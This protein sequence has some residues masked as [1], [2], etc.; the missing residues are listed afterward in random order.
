[1][2]KCFMFCKEYTRY[3][4]KLAL[5]SFSPLFLCYIPDIVLYLWTYQS[6]SRFNSVLHI[7]TPNVLL[8][9]PAAPP[10]KS[11]S[12]LSLVSSVR[13]SSVH[14][15]LLIKIQQQQQATFSIFS[16]LEQ[17]CLYTFII[18]FHFHLVF[19]IKNRTR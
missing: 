6:N 18:H 14:H 19:N 1:M 8:A 13:S 15:G 11:E 17:S 2:S 3:S 10:A 12:P 7:S 5:I 9:H 16:N 4:P